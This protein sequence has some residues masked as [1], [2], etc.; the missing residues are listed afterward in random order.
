[1]PADWLLALFEVLAITV[2]AWIGG[3]V[4]QRLRQP[5]IA[6]EM[7]AVFVAGL[8]LGGQIA[9]VVP[10]QHADGRI[11]ALF[12][13]ATL[14]LVAAVGGLGLVLYMLLVG[15]SVDLAPMRHQAGP[16]LS[17]A[18]ATAGAMA[19]LALVVG[20]LLV[21]AGGWK[22]AG[23]SEGAF[24]LAVAATLAANGLPV[25]ARVLEDRA[26][27]HSAVGSIVIVAATVATAVALIA[28]AVAT[29]GGDLAAGG[30]LVGLRAGVGLV[31]VA[32]VIAVAAVS[33]ARAG[34]HGG[35]VAIVALAGAAAWA[36]AA[37]LQPADR[38]ARRR[39][40]RRQGRA[41]GER[42]RTPP[43]S[44]GATRRPA[45]V[46][47]AGGA[48]HGP[49]GD[50]LTVLA[51]VLAMLASVILIKL[52]AGYV[53]ARLA[54]LPPAEARSIGALMQCGGVMTIAM[55]LDVLDAQLIDA[56]MH[57][58]LTLLGLT[59]TVVA[60]PLMARARPRPDRALVVHERS[61]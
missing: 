34:P 36:V 46:P 4:A 6:G 42:R 44:C 57:A 35:A 26:M 52:A 5:R 61:V 28:A 43:R 7:A 37:A 31:L 51:P 16:I 58:T 19:V 11:A 41:R 10:G 2:V 14:L 29:D 32:V 56:R 17:V 50:R 33:P 3:L 53:A 27:Q 40:R 18:A 12:P 39:H 8:L 55:S 20:P 1:M 49:A 60:A 30:A 15:I 23:V 25:V 21:D 24:V 45:G 22:P 48:A 59:T 47:R 9:D 54:G 13:E 38:A